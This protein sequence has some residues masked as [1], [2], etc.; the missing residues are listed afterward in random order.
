MINPLQ[1]KA[2]P[3][4]IHFFPLWHN[5]TEGVY[6][7][8]GTLDR[9]QIVLGRC[10]NYA[11]KPYVVS[12]PSKLCHFCWEHPG[13]NWQKRE[14]TSII[15]WHDD[16][17]HT[18]DWKRRTTWGLTVQSETGQSSEQHTSTPL[19]SD[20]PVFTYQHYVNNAAPSCP[21]SNKI[22]FLKD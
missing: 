22:F 6:L 12:K 8:I 15:P 9:L 1:V 2:N 3:F 4:L 13:R 16:C 20:K 10:R 7:L 18:C 14:R 17:S 19:M 5:M 21:Y 11:E